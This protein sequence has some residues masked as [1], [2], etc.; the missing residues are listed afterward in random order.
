MPRPDLVDG[1]TLGVDLGGTHLRVAVF[2]P[3]GSIHAR[4]REATPADDRGVLLRTA[5][6]AIADAPDRPRAFVLGVAGPVSYLEGRVLRLPNLPAW[7]EQRSAQ[8]LADALA[9]PVLIANDADLAA[10][11]EHRFGA[12]RGTRD[13]LYITV[14]TG[15]GGGVVLDGRLLHGR[16]SLAEVGGATVDLV[17]GLTVEEQGSGTALSRLSGMDGEATLARARSG[18]RV[19][20]DAFAE[21]SAVLAAGVMNAICCFMP[22]RVVIGGGV[23]AA[24]D[25]LLDPIRAYVARVGER[26]AIQPEIVTAARGDDAGLLGAFALRQDVDAG[27]TSLSFARPHRSPAPGTPGTG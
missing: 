2:N 7:D 4:Q 5:R 15:V 8:S 13:M 14:S 6:S 27:R 18:D 16:R 10:L 11:G 1:M 25:L 23:S 3:D 21:V 22:E 24:G 20:L 19:A 9:L 12:G 17:A 26:L